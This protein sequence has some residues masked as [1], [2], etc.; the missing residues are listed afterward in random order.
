MTNL[1]SAMTYVPYNNAS[2]KTF[3][4]LSASTRNKQLSLNNKTKFDK[5]SKAELK[6]WVAYKSRC[7]WKNFS[8]EFKSFLIIYT[9]TI[10][11]YIRSI[12]IR[13]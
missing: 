13:E 4:S 11:E 12:Q 9:S 5:S 6:N 2:L 10:S 7:G 3:K 1:I 8:S